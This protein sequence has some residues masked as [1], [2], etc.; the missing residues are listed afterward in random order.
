VGPV[1][2]AGPMTMAGAEARLVGVHGYEPAAAREVLRGMRD[3]ERA[4]PDRRKYATYD[5]D[6]F[7]IDYSTAGARFGQGRFTFLE[8]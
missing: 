3:H 6:T 7:S 2:T 4:R 5:G 1:I 8:D